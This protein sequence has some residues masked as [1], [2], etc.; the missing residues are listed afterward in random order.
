MRPAHEIGVITVLSGTACFGRMKLCAEVIFTTTVGRM[1]AMCQ[2]AQSMG[3][4]RRRIKR[5]MDSQ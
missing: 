5:P 3:F 4:K 1:L 2:Q